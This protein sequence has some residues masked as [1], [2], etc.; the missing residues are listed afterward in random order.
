MDRGALEPIKM[1]FSTT[2]SHSMPALPAH[3]YYLYGVTLC[4]SA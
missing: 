3:A 4:T 1:L 2:D